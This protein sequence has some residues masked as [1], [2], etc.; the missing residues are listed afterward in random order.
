MHSAERVVFQG[1]CA[2]V[3]SLELNSW[4]CDFGG[5]SVPVHIPPE[6]R[7]AIRI[8]LYWQLDTIRWFLLD[9]YNII[10]I[11]YI[12]INILQITVSLRDSFWDQIYGTHGM[13]RSKAAL[14][15]LRA[16]EC[17]AIISPP[18]LRVLCAEIFVWSLCKISVWE[19][20]DFQ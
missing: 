3:L 14:Q 7:K 10:M 1:R 16:A 6:C 17:L 20:S 13:I 2:S 11:I 9:N 19:S 15:P 18:W 12:Y 4:R 5:A 8:L